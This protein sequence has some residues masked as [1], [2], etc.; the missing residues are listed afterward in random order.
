ME[1]KLDKDEYTVGYA[2]IGG[3]VLVLTNFRLFIDR[4]FRVFGERTKSMRIKDIIDVKFSKSFLFGTGIDIK[5]VEENS[6]R[7]IFSEFAVPAKAK[8]IIDMIHSLQKGDILM[9]VEVPKGET[10]GISLEE[11]ERIALDFMEKKSSGLKVD[12]IKHFAGAWNIILSNHDR[13]AVVVGDDGKVEAWKK[14]TR[15]PG[16]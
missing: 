10:G 12:E 4:G 14:I 5:Y 1:L 2:R 9:P 15:Q 8:K 13:Y 6:E 11:A 16:L 7:T 3:G